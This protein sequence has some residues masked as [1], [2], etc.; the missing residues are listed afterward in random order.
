MNGR[1]VPTE[2][3]ELAQRAM[4]MAGITAEPKPEAADAEESTDTVIEPVPVPAAPPSAA[5]QWG[6]HAFVIAL[7]A[8]LVALVLR[9]TW[10]S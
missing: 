4:E 3:V 7:A 6:T 9:Y 5:R 2:E 10:F 1:Y 8:A